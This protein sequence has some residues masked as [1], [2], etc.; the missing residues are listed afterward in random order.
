M[1]VGEVR[2]LSEALGSKVVVRLALSVA[3][4]LLLRSLLVCISELL[5]LIEA[6]VKVR[7]EA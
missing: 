5:V 6:G 2:G 7:V 4:K 1:R 3:L